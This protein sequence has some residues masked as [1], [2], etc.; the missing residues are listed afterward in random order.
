M[1]INQLFIEKKVNKIYLLVDNQMRIKVIR[2][3]KFL[4]FQISINKEHLDVNCK[5]FSK[6]LK[7]KSNSFFKNQQKQL[8][9]NHQIQIFKCQKNSKVFR[10]QKQNH[11]LDTI[12]NNSIKTLLEILQQPLNQR[13]FRIKQLKIKS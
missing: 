7:V 2:S 1:Q 6:S 12:K 5:L 3:N 8:Y 13:S 10:L 4:K 11:L 9:Q